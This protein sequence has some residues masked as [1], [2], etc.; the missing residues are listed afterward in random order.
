MGSKFSVQSSWVDILSSHPRKPLKSLW[1]LRLQDCFSCAMFCA[2]LVF[3]LA[4]LISFLLDRSN[5]NQNMYV[6]A[7]VHLVHCAAVAINEQRP[8]KIEPLTP[9]SSLRKRETRL[10]LSS[11][12]ASAWQS[13]CQSAAPRHSV[14][15]TCVKAPDEGRIKP[16]LA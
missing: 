5:H 1:T 3:C 11:V 4:M 12:L 6:I 7:S 9:R 15:L 16:F 13:D 10:F 14:G 8:T 2:H